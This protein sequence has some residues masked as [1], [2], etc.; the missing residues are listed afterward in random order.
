MNQR[1]N[2]AAG[3]AR[4]G[5]QRILNQQHE[6]RSDF[7]NTICLNVCLTF[8]CVWVG[9]S[10]VYSLTHSPRENQMNERSVDR[11]H[12]CVVEVEG[13]KNSKYGMMK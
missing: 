4:S 12:V 7:S 9:P 3:G 2:N 1:T 8:A 13:C 6:R 10:S 5:H 11:V